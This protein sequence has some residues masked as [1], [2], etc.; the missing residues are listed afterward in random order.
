MTRET[1]RPRS[2]VSSFLAVNNFSLRVY[3]LVAFLDRGPQLAATFLEVLLE[4][5][6]DRLNSSQFGRRVFLATLSRAFNVIL[7]PR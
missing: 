3:S 6:D 5:P 7:D 1:L 2:I 4:F